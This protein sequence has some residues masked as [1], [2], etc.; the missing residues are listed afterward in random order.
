LALGDGI[1]EGEA[2]AA[3]DFGDGDGILADAARA[4][5]VVVDEGDGTPL[6]GGIDDLE[7][8]IGDC[9]VL[10]VLANHFRILAHDGAGIDHQSLVALGPAVHFFFQYAPVVVIEFGVLGAHVG[11]IEALRHRGLV[12]AHVHRGR[13]VAAAVAAAA[14]FPVLGACFHAFVPGI[15]VALAVF[16]ARGIGHINHRSRQFIGH[17]VGNPV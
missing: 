5:P 4:G 10:F 7:E 6:L 3:L 9:D 2:G 13:H 11:H 15:V 16:M 8:G 12:P 1:G 17:T 14:V